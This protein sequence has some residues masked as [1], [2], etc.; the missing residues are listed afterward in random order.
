M[1]LFGALQACARSSDAGSVEATPSVDGG[2]AFA[3][4]GQRCRDVPTSVSG[5]VL[6]PATTNPDPVYNAVVYV[7]N[8][9][10]DHVFTLPSV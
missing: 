3:D 9:P 7:P 1:V 5:V 8:A 2:G 10:V 6:S 4:G